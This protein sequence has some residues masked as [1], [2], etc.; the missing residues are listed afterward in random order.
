MRKTKIQLPILNGKINFEFMEDFISELEQAKIRELEAYL[1][2]TGLSNYTL[3]K[4][5]NEY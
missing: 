1:Q 4:K 5:K 3:T 2:A